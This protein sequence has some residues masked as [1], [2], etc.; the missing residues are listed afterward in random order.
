MDGICCSCNLI[1]FSVEYHLKTERS[2]EILQN[3]GLPWIPPKKALG[4]DLSN[5]TE[6][7]SG[8]IGVRIALFLF[9]TAL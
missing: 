5:L 3:S 1:L 4:L 7:I 8:A 2:T 9:T 6:T